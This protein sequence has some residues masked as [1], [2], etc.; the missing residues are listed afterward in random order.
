MSR[1]LT[2]EQKLTQIE[3]LLESAVELSHSNTAK[4]D[5]NTEAIK[6]NNESSDRI[7]QKV[8]ANAEAIDAL[9]NRVDRDR[10]FGEDNLD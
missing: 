8:E 3:K 2:P 5:A 4:I 7:G 6:A 9:T 1:E 10:F